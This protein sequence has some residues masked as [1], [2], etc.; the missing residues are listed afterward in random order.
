[1]VA[2]PTSTSNGAAVT[3]A[4][5]K[6]TIAPCAQAGRCGAAG[7][8]RDRSCRRVSKTRSSAVPRDR[9]AATTPDTAFATSTPTVRP[10]AVRG[11]GSTSLDVPVQRLAVG[12]RSNNSPSCGSQCSSSDAFAKKG[13]VDIAFAYTAVWNCDGLDHTDK[14]CTMTANSACGNGVCELVGNEHEY[15]CPEDCSG[16]DGSDPGCLE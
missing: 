11:P 7:P 15:N 2:T 9:R 13:Y 16:C 12:T 4:A 8:D 14:D 1:M 3:T 6:A 10:T 5:S